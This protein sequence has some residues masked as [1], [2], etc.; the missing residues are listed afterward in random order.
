MNK[1]DPAG[2]YGKNRILIF[3]SG[4]LLFVLIFIRASIA[5][6]VCINWQWFG[7][8]EFGPQ[9]VNVKDLRCNDLQSFGL[10]FIS[11]AELQLLNIDA[12]GKF[13]R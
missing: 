6:L 12:A 10:D 7:L 11:Y 1:L 2:T 13:L 8:S 9:H 4:E 5:V 3:V